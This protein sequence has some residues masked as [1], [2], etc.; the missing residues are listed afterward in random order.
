MKNMDSKVLGYVLIAVGVILIAYSGFNVYQVFT[1]KTQPVQVFNFD[2][3]SM[4]L[5]GLL[6]VPTKNA[7][8]LE[9]LP[10]EILNQTSNL[11]AHLFLM[12]FIVNIGSKIANLG[13]Y[14]V[15]PINVTLK[16]GSK[17]QEKIQ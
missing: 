8:E 16:D 14:L 3:I 1:K 9:L 15:R 2:G 4:S 6:D 7:P 5:G 11:V 12:G 13:V 10:P 17:N